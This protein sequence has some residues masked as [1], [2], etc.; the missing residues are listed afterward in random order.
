MSVDAFNSKNHM[1][2]AHVFPGGIP[3]GESPARV[4]SAPGSNPS[5]IISGYDPPLNL[6]MSNSRLLCSVE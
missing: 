5:C 6:E 4:G 1:H 3:R 2:L